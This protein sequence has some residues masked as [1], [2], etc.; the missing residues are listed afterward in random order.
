MRGDGCRRGG[1]A[2]TDL[3][4]KLEQKPR[5]LASADPPSRLGIVITGPQDSWRLPEGRI[6]MSRVDRPQER[7]RF[8]DASR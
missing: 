3:L 4:H 6:D 5:T 8:S 2:L 7:E 1:R